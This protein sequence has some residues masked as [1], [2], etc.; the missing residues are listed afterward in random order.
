MIRLLAC[1]ALLLA[2]LASAGCAVSHDGAAGEPPPDDPPPDDPPPVVDPT[3]LPLSLAWVTEDHGAFGSHHGDLAPSGDMALRPAAF[4]G[5]AYEAETGEP[6]GSSEH[7]VSLDSG[8]V[9]GVLGSSDGTV[10][11]VEIGTGREVAA[12]PGA[13]RGTGPIAAIDAAGERLFAVDCTH[14]GAATVRIAPLSGDEA[15]N[16]DVRDECHHPTYAAAP[17]VL[18]GD[19]DV[20]VAGVGEATIDVVDLA[21]GE[22]RGRTLETGDPVAEPLWPAG[23]AIASAARSPDGATL[24]V[25]TMDG[26]LRLLTT[27]S[28]EV[29]DERPAG[30]FV[31]NQDS[32]LPSVASPVAFHPGGEHLAHVDPEGN[33]SVIRLEDGRVV[34]SI[35]PP[36]DPPAE[37]RTWPAHPRVPMELRFVRDGLLGSFEGGVVRWVVDGTAL[38]PRRR[39]ALSVSISAPGRAVVGEPIDVRTSV[40]GSSVMRWIELEDGRVAS[41]GSLDPVIRTHLYEAGVHRASVVVSDGARTG[42]AEWTVEVSEGR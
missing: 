3:W 9:H 10:T 1:F 12:V 40:E 33:V 34:Q 42:R 26:R 22:L 30:V 38:E 21:T 31:A 5:R 19:G 39:A 2:P 25:V 20:V 15:W 13:V 14:A 24:A 16:V 28:L 18:P 17:V 6:I 8:W 37:E 27:D 35:V 11:A 29:V 23:T 36:F 4:G 7:Y 41:Q 32:Y